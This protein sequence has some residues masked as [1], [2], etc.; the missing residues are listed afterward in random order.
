MRY[1]LDVAE[2]PTALYPVNCMNKQQTPANIPDEHK[3]PVQIADRIWWVGHVLPDDP[4]QCHV[5]LIENGDQS[6]LVDPGSMLTFKHTLAKIEQIMPFSQIRYFIC[7][8]QAI[9]GP[10]PCSNTWDSTC[11]SAALKKWAGA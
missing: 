3:K 5:Y 1:S 10:S 9:G 11:P 6:V 2:A 7:H 4:F 8:H